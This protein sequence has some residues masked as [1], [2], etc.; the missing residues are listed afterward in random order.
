[1]T[2]MPT[3]QAFIPPQA[4]L[5]I[6]EQVQCRGATN[7]ISDAT[8]SCRHFWTVSSLD[9]VATVATVAGVSAGLAALC[10]SFCIGASMAVAS[11]GIL[12]LT[13][14]T[15]LIFQAQ[16]LQ[17]LCAPMSANEI[18]IAPFDALDSRSTPLYVQT[19]T[20][21]GSEACLSYTWCPTRSNAVLIICIIEFVFDNQN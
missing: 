15:A 11:T 8:Y 2:G 19:L 7:N 14:I 6:C 4:V 9:H 20:P 21:P 18:R 3:Q 17:V 12:T 16:S 5:G 13:S 1:M 10:R